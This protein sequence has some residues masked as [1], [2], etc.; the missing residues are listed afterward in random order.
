VGL[1]QRLRD[2]GVPHFIVEP[3]P[4]RAAQLVGEDIS[5]V[6]GENDSGATYRNLRAGAARLMGQPGAAPRVRGAFRGQR[7]GTLGAPPEG[8]PPEGVTAR[9]LI[10]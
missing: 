9:Q 3:D 5:V 7:S 4:T 8:A 2:E 1:V 10:R 6:A